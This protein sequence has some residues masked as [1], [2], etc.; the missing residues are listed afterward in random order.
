MRR[1]HRWPQGL[2]SLEVKVREPIQTKQ[3]SSTDTDRPWHPGFSAWA[4]AVS[5][6]ALISCWCPLVTAQPLFSFSMSWADLYGPN[7]LG[8]ATLWIP[9]RFDP[10]EEMTDYQ[11]MGRWWFCPG[12]SFLFQHHVKA[13]S[14]ND[15]SSFGWRVLHNPALTRN[16]SGYFLPLTLRA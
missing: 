13:T 8:F 10:W 2:P 16:P 6:C 5:N 3:Y 9:S 14:L 15:H 4:L 12:L 1:I 7:N 11:T